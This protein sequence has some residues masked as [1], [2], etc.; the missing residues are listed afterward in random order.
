MCVYVCHYVPACMCVCVLYWHWVYTY[1]HIIL[2]LIKESYEC[3]WACTG[4][5][6]NTA[7]LSMLREIWLFS[8]QSNIQQF[9]EL[10][11]FSE[12]SAKIVL[13]TCKR[14]HTRWIFLLTANSQNIFT[15]F[16]HGWLSFY[17][18]HLLTFRL[19]IQIRSSHKSLHQ[20][21]WLSLICTKLC[22][23]F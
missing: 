22:L 2:L 7:L 23:P 9:N 19:W 6:Q 3:A 1:I 11:K 5:Q 15:Y 10:F 8:I 18:F 12:L 13:N 4:R 16:V 20:S 14:T 21:F 17:E